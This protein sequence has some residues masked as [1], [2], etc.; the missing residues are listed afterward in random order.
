[1]PEHT[2]QHDRRERRQPEGEKPRPTAFLDTLEDFP[3]QPRRAEIELHNRRVV[4][5]ARWF[6]LSPQVRQANPHVVVPTFPAAS[7]EASSTG[8][9]DLLR[10]A[11]KAAE[12]RVHTL[13]RLVGRSSCAIGARYPW[14]SGSIQIKG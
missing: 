12:P 8:V 3:P 10:W 1:M 13:R 14:L 2:L 5:Q 4:A 7:P 9:P 6:F 11:G